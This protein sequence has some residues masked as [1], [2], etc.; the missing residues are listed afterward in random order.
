MFKGRISSCL[1]RVLRYRPEGTPNS[2]AL[3]F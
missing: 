2:T 3:T 1:K